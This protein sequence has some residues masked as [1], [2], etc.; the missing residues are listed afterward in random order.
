[1]SFLDRFRRK[2]QGEAARIARLLRTGRI[3]EG[4]IIDVTSDNSGHIAQVFYSY[5]IA[6]VEYE[7][8]QVLNAEQQSRRDAY[9]PGARIIIRYYPHQPGNSVVV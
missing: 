2:K 9:Q 3:V 6:G 1:M 4:T 7:S 5:N 8:S